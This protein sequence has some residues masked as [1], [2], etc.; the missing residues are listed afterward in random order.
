MKKKEKPVTPALAIVQIPM[1]EWKGAYKPEQAL[2]AGTMFEELDKPF[3][4]GG[5]KRG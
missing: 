2:K 3:F 4:T 5:K 1:Q